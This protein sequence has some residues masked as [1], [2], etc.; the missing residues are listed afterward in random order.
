MNIQLKK[1]TVSLFFIT[2]LVCGYRVAAAADQA[3]NP[4]LQMDDTNQAQPD[5]V[6]PEVESAQQESNPTQEYSRAKVIDIVDTQEQTAL[7]TTQFYQKLKVKFTSGKEKGKETEIEFKDVADK[8]TN[9]KLQKGDTVVVVKVQDG[10]QVDY[11][12]ID[13]YRIPSVIILLVVL[14]ILAFLIA[15]IKGLL[16]FV[17]FAVVL[18]MVLKVL[19]PQVLA[20]HPALLI[21]LGVALV[22]AVVMHYA[23]RG[24]SRHASLAVLSTIVTTIIVGL[25]TYGLLAASKIFGVPS[26]ESVYAQTFFEGVINLKGLMLSGI[27]LTIVGVISY[28]SYAQTKTVINRLA[29]LAEKNFKTIFM[30][31]LKNGADRTAAL[32]AIL[33]LF[34]L[35]IN[36]SLFLLF[37]VGTNQPAWILLNSEYVI[38]EI[39][40]M[41]MGIL[42]LL[43]TV[44][45]ATAIAAFVY[46]RPVKVAA[47]SGA[48]AE[49]TPD[50]STPPVN[51]NS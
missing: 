22:A 26:E 7:G 37:S 42:A 50:T 14:L 23:S 44:P 2:L 38:G 5:G 49:N 6:S 9:R 46:G 3:P 16:T 35:G 17:G 39:I 41:S 8:F 20:G 27:M 34:Y 13:Q 40:Y 21:A 1:L 19:L 31:G 10:E 51:T 43:L 18:F 48:T 4:E 32:L 30:T 24:F 28:V 25:I 12:V 29:D 47:P 36:V 11:Q 33:F 45:I 15:R